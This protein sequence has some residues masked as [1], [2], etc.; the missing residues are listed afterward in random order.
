[1]RNIIEPFKKTCQVIAETSV[2][3]DC[4]GSMHRLSKS[5]Q[6][7]PGNKIVLVDHTKPQD[8]ATQNQ[9]AQ[10]TDDEEEQDDV[11]QGDTKLTKRR[12]AGSLKERATGSLKTEL[13]R[14]K[15]AKYQEGRD[16]EPSTRSIKPE[17]SKSGTFATVPEQQP[18][19]AES[20]QADTE[21]QGFRIDKHLYRRG[22]N[23]IHQGKKQISQIVK[24]RRAARKEPDADI[25]VDILYENQRG[26]FLFGVP[27]FSSNSLLQLDPKAWQTCDPTDHRSPSDTVIDQPKTQP[28]PS[29]NSKSPHQKRAHQPL[30]RP[31]PVDITNAQVPDPCWEWGWPSWYVDMAHDVDEEGWEYSFSFGTPP[32]RSYGWHGSQKPWWHAFVRRRRW[33]RMRRRQHAHRA[34]GSIVGGETGVKSEREGHRVHTSNS[35]YFTV[36]SSGNKGETGSLAQ[37]SAIGGWF[38]Q[39]EG[40]ETEDEEI[41]DISALMKKLKKAAI[42]REKIGAVKRFLK[43][44]GEDVYYLAEYVSPRPTSLGSLRAIT[45]LSHQMPQIMTLLVFQTSRRH[46]LALLMHT[47]ASASHHRSTQ[48]STPN[49]PTSPQYATS[50]TSPAS[51]ASPTSHSTS[52][53]QPHLGP[54]S[55]AEKH[56]IDSL[57]A[58]ARVADREIRNLEFWSDIKDVVRDGGDSSLESPAD[59]GDGWQGIDQSGPEAGMR[60]FGSKEE[61]DARL[62]GRK[63]DPRGE[64]RE[65]WGVAVGDFHPEERSG[66]GERGERGKDEKGK[67]RA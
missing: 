7:G 27:F 20:A 33:I 3:L 32:Y 35:E 50:P 10:A 52:S 1:M 14:R 56:Y 11:P 15:Y 24:G 38:P 16:S 26:T 13:T 34:D 36:R 6:R 65:M 25:V 58:A 66:V 47:I 57:L 42:D 18:L 22:R 28:S 40:E 4:E 37:T 19:S 67:G 17:S 31:S 49:S 51:P 12:T 2:A 46:L 21:Q 59:W 8:E 64:G 30:L 62:G 41:T 63:P 60:P 45:H 48:H 43:D 53:P 9:S 39:H 54:E 44:S 55:P 61:G 29:A 5:D 23:Q